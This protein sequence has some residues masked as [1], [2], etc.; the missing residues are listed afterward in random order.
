MQAIVKLALEPEWEPRFEPNSYGFRPGRCPMDAIEAI[1]VT[2]ARKGSSQWVLDAD[3]AKC[4]DAASDC[5]L[6]HEA[7]WKRSVWAWI[8]LIRKPFCRPRR[9]WIASSSP[10]LTRC[11]TV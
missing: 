10:R 8:S 4:L 7:C 5:P 2:L 11:H 6:V 1:H 9:T 3:I